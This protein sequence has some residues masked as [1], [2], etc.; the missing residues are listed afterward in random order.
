M[1]LQYTQYKG[2]VNKLTSHSEENMIETVYFFY[3]FL[4]KT[5]IGVVKVTV[6][7]VI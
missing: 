6:L 4:A 2:K 7:S 3:V 5:Y 1:H